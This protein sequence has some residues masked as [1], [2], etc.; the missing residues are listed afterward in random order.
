MACRST[1]RF[2][3]LQFLKS[4]KPSKAIPKVSVGFDEDHIH[5]TD[6]TGTDRISWNALGGISVMTNNHGPWAEDLFVVLFEKIE[7]SEP[8]S[9]FEIPGNAANLDSLLNRFKMLPGFN[10]TELAKALGS[11]DNAYF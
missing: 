8:L 6:M 9:K 5:V 1:C 10:Q 7:G 11:T 3:M 4:R 2:G